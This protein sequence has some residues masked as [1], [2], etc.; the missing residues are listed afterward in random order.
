[1]LRIV[2]GDCPPIPE[3]FRD[4]LIVFLE[5]CFHKEPAQHPNAEELL[6]HEWLKDYCGLKKV[7]QNVR[8]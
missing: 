7:R 3:S 8:V 4:P 2:K 6:T 1:M 5:E